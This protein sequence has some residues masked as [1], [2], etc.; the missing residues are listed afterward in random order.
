MFDP[1]ILLEINIYCQDLISFVF[2]RK[3][4]FIYILSYAA[5]HPGLLKHYHTQKHEYK[6][7]HEFNKFWTNV[8]SP[9]LQ[10]TTFSRTLHE[11]T[12]GA[13][14]SYTTNISHLVGLPL[15]YAI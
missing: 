14:T 2:T 6:T 8:L 12:P 7:P 11:K 10:E 1:Y 5:N 15:C 4:F 9:Q 13:S 3:L